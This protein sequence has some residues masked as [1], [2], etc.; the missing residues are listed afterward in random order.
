MPAYSISVCYALRVC[1][2]SARRLLR[3]K[4]PNLPNHQQRNGFIV[5]MTTFP[6]L[7][8]PSPDVYR[9]R[10]SIWHRSHL[11]GEPAVPY[12]LLLHATPFWLFQRI[13]LRRSP[14]RR[15]SFF[16]FTHRLSLSRP[17]RFGV[18]FAETSH[19]AIVSA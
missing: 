14:S 13:F 17:F 6:L 18:A 16:R 2:D 5:L 9:M 12:G 11:P 1:V 10:L 4:R 7:E 3:G 19:S 15:D 8:R